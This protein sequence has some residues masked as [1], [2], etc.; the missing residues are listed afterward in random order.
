MAVAIPT[1]RTNASRTQIGVL[2]VGDQRTGRSYDPT[3]PR[4]IAEGLRRLAGDEALRNDLKRRGA[5]HFASYS[6]A[7]FARRLVDIL[8]RARDLTRSRVP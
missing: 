3:D 6:A 5:E 2:A 8:H 7:D 4:S 1:T